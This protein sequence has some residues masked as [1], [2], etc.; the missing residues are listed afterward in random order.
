M[1]I[2]LGLIKHKEKYIKFT[3]RMPQVDPSVSIPLVMDLRST[4]PLKTAKQEKEHKYYYTIGNAML[5]FYNFRCNTFSEQ[6]V[7]WFLLVYLT[8]I[9]LV[10]KLPVAI[11]SSLTLKILKSFEDKMISCE[12]YQNISKLLRNIRITQ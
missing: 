5:T 3:K 4:K 7:V 10:M 2:L 9:S 8:Q 11:K 6:F 1:R 12:I